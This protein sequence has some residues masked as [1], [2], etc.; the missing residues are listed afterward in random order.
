M[1]NEAAVAYFKVL[2]RHLRLVAEKIYG[3]ISVRIVG[4]PAE[5]RTWYLPNT[6]QKIY[7]LT[8]FA[9]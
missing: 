3:Y 8:R 6:S 9:R 2:S 4:V 7:W 1:W 5:S